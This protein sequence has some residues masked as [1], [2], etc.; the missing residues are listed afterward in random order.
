MALTGSLTIY[1]Y[2]T[3]STD[4]FQTTVQYPADLPESSPYYEHRGTTASIT[5]PV[6]VEATTTYSGSYVFISA[7][8]VQTLDVKNNANV[9][10]LNYIYRVYNSQAAKNTD[11]E[12]YLHTD[13][14]NTNWD[15]DTNSNPHEAAYTHFKTIQGAGS[16]SNN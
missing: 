8:S 15:W 16:L 14:I 6:M 9:V 12:D 13:T 11:W 2:T 10:N 4:T 5:N 1:S 3:H 7:A